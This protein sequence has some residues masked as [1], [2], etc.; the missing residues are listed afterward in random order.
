M[1]L[2]ANDAK[3]FGNNAFS[4]QQ[5]LYKFANWLQLHQLDLAVTKCEHLCIS[6]IHCSNPFFVGSLNIETVSVIKDLGIYISNN[7]KWSYH[8]S[9][10]HHNAS[11]CSYQI[12][13]SFSTKNVWILLEAFNTYVRFKVEFNTYVFLESLF[14]KGY[15]S[16]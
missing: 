5:G 14:K 13:R 15:C 3:L 2:Y 8:L 4:L 1:F 12:L 10:I 6:C 11:L 7:L 16:S 9:H